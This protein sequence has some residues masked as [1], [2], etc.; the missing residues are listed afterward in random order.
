M[1]MEKQKTRIKTPWHLWF[2]GLFFIF[3]NGVGVYDYF[4]MLGH[5]PAYYSSLNLG[6][7]VFTYFT[8]YPISFKIFWIINL[9]SG[10][11]ASILLL[12]RNRWAVPVALI[13]V[14]SLIILDVLTFGFRDRWH[15][16]GPWLSLFDIAILLMMFGLFL[17]CR[18]MIKRGV[19]R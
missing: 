1:K 10:L 5:N 3:L 12:F 9:S 17:Y 18:M 16:F 4:M 19:L 13:C 8:D 14:S 7:A 2:I 11:I 15:V 6:E